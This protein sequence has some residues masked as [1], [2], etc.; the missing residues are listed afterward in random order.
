[1]GLLAAVWNMK[2]TRRGDG[3][4]REVQIEGTDVD[5]SKWPIQTC[6]PGDAAPLITWALVITRGPQACRSHA[7]G[8]TS[9]SIGNR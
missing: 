6:W 5:L 7:R 8:R 9:A 4:C 2:P 3:P 1:M